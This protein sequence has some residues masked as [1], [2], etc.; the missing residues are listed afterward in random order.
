ML[1]SKQWDA[2]DKWLASPGTLKELIKFK[3]TTTDKV[4]SIC[5]LTHWSQGD[6]IAVSPSLIANSMNWKEV[7]AKVLAATKTK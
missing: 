3:A 6:K 7:E 1:N 2:I 4:A 5:Y